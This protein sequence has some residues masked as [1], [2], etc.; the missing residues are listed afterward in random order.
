M[1]VTAPTA[2]GTVFQIL[3]TAKKTDITILIFFKDE[4]L[5][6]DT[7]GDFTQ[8]DTAIALTCL[9]WNSGA[10]GYKIPLLSLIF[11]IPFSILREK[12]WISQSLDQSWG[13]KS[14]CKSFVH[15]GHDFHHKRQRNDQK[16]LEIV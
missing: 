13:H 5:N 15:V 11:I 9:H 16:S 1:P 12:A 4:K 2:L 8:R 7:V 10:F 14:I 3:T 6:L